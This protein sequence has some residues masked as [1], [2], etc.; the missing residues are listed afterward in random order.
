MDAAVV[1]SSY[2]AKRDIKLFKQ[3]VDWHPETS[4]S[5]GYRRWVPEWGVWAVQWGVLDQFTDHMGKREWIVINL[6]ELSSS[7]GV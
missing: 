3:D 1:S 7:D 2:A 6:P 5:T 4:G